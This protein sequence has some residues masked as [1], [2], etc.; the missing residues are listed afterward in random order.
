MST[1]SRRLFSDRELDLL[2]TPLSVRLQRAAVA[3]DRDAAVEVS[4][5]YE[6]ECTTVYGDR[7][8]AALQTFIISEAGEQAHDAAVR[9]AGRH[10]F[11]PFIQRYRNK[12]LRERVALVARRLRASGSTFWVEQDDQ[13]IRFR[14]D[15]WGPVRHWRAPAPWQEHAAR[16]LVGDRYLYPCSGDVA[17][18]VSL[19]LLSE[20]QHLTH[21]RELVPC[22]LATE[23]LFFE[24]LPIDEL[25]WPVGVISLP[26]EPDEP[27]FLDVYRDPRAVP[28]ELYER[29]DRLKPRHMPGSASADDQLDRSDVARLGVPLSLRIREAATNKRWDRLIEIAAGMDAELVAAKDPLSILRTGLLTWIAR[30]LGEDAVERV[31]M[32]SAAI[33]M[34][35]WLDVAETVSSRRFVEQLAGVWRAHG[36]TFNMQETQHTVIFRGRPMGACG[37]LWSSTG[38]QVP[39]ACGERVRYPTFGCYE[40]PA[41]LHLLRQ[42]RG[43]TTMRPDY[44][45]YS[46]HCHVFHEIFPIDRIGRPLWAETHALGDRSGEVV[47]VFYKDPRAWP[48]RYYTRVGRHK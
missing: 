17:P 46:A 23:V 29:V 26:S 5:L 47:H 21:A 22:F 16:K 48:K 20:S 40:P 19:A 30:H 18:P 28:R 25:G 37:R 35:P 36:S 4:E 3:G 39:E 27:A 43:M 32:W 9:E 31:L 12:T 44:P 1:G 33:I 14:L 13:L 2:A 7:W 11:L 10:A 38:P 24:I 15:P 8:T 42:P 6:Q 34:P 41:S 45:V